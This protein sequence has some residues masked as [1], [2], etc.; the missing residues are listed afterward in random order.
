MRFHSAAIVLG[1]A[2]GLSGLHCGGE[3]E[4]PLAFRIGVSSQALLAD[5]EVVRVQLHPGNIDCDVLQLTGPD[6]EAVYSLE[7]DL[8]DD[9]RGTLFN[10]VEDIYTVDGWG[11][12]AGGAPRSYGCGGTVVV[13]RGRL[14][15]AMITMSPIPEI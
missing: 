3:E 4:A 11:F 12:E 1:L 2:G 14:T 10:V 9:D 8:D 6:F 5:L 15:E 13:R 7:I